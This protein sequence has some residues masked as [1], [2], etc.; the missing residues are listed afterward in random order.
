MNQTNFTFE[1]ENLVVDWISFKFQNLD[2]KKE[3]EITNYLFK[4]GFNIYQQSA[5][6]AKPVKQVIRDNQSNRFEVL[7]VKDHAYWE[8]S[9]LNFSGSNASTFYRLIQEKSIDW[10]IFSFG[11]LSQ[12]DLCYT[13]NSETKE[14]ILVKEFLENCQKKL[15]QKHQ[16]VILE[17]NREG[18]VLRIG[19]RR[20]NNYIRIYRKKDTLRFELEMKGKLIENYHSFLI[21]ECLNQF[22]DK[23]FSY[24]FA[25]LAK[26][27]PLEFAYFDWLVLKLRPI[28]KQ[29]AFGL[30]F[31]SDYFQVKSKIQMDKKTFIIFL[32]FLNYVQNLPSKTDYLGDVPYPKVSFKVA[33]FLNYQN[34]D[35]ISSRFYQYEK[36]KKLLKKFQGGVFLTSFSSHYY[37]S[38]AAVPQVQLKQSSKKQPW[39]AEVWVVK[40]LFSY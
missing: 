22:E 28:P 21:S 24:F 1:S 38:L 20:T 2:Q 31:K 6:L 12:F 9:R 29:S 10:R 19:N 34:P 37:Q 36:M 33:D 35:W 27:L 23:L 16:N 15:A 17:K 40:E 4:L 30:D 8:G 13:R 39:I 14:K 7:F 11:L 25:Y 26:L 3:Q 5:K 32:Q 18:F